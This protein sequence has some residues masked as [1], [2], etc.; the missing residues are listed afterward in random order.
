VPFER[1][2]CETNVLES[3]LDWDIWNCVDDAVDVGGASLRPPRFARFG[4]PFC[5]EHH[6]TVTVGDQSLSTASSAVG[7]DN[8]G[9]EADIGE[10]PHTCLHTG[11][12][13][14]QRCYDRK[15]LRLLD[16]RTHTNERRNLVKLSQESLIYPCPRTYLTHTRITFLFLAGDDSITGG[17]TVVVTLGWY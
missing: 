5:L 7:L 3:T 9:E 17:S 1:G 16:H 12:P 15:H 11:R 13:Y 2:V 4:L 10:P 8:D 6:Q 14:L